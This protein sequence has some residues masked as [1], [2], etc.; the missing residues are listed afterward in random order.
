MIRTLVF[1]F[2]FSHFP[3]LVVNI[4]GRLYA[5]FYVAQHHHRMSANPPNPSNHTQKSPGQAN[6]EGCTFRRTIAACLHPYSLEA[7]AAPRD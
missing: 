3:I 7:P 6:G 4:F 1:L 2:C 5:Y